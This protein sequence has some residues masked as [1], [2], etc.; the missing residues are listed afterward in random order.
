M[1]AQC[2]C[3][4]V[5]ICDPISIRYTLKSL[6]PYG[7]TTKGLQNCLLFKD[8]SFRSAKK[9]IFLMEASLDYHFTINSFKKP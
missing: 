8:F 3:I 1:I 7:N 9:A 5:S 4:K 2:F 6:K